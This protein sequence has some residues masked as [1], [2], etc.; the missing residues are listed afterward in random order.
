MS[1]SKTKTKAFTKNTS[2]IN[3]TA[4]A[5][6]KAEKAAP[7]VGKR[8]DVEIKY[9]KTKNVMDEEELRYNTF[10]ASNPRDTRL[11]SQWRNFQ[12][13]KKSPMQL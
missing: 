6:I 5:K 4:A 8:D 12:I 9:N 11:Q 13:A 3:L 2:Y 1:K 10:Q 7:A